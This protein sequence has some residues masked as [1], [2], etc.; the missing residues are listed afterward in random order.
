MIS[1]TEI[2][3]MVGIQGIISLSNKV[4]RNIATGKKKYNYHKSSYCFH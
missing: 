3:K 2:A 1:A 4:K